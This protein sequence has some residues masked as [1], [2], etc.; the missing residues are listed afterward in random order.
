MDLDCDP[1]QPPPAK[2]TTEPNCTTIDSLGDD[3]LREILLLLPSLT[4]LIRAAFTCRA[5]R[6]AVASSPSF[7]RRFRALHPSPPLGLFFTRPRSVHRPNVPALPDFVPTRRPDK[8]L[9]AAVRCGDF[10]I[11]SIP[12]RRGQ[13]PCW[14]IVDCRDGLL[15]LND[16]DNALLGLFNPYSRWSRGVFD[17]PDGDIFEDYRG[18]YGLRSIH[19]IYSDED[20]MSFRVVCLVYDESRVRALV[21]SPSDTRG[22]HIGPWVEVSPTPQTDSEWLEEGMQ[23]NGLFIFWVCVDLK[24]VITLNTTTMEFSVDEFPQ[25]LTAVDQDVSFD[26]GETMDGAPCIVYAVGLSIGVLLRKADDDGVEKWVQDR[27]VPLETQLARII[28][29]LPLPGDLQ[30]NVAAIRN[31]FVYLATSDMY[32][33]PQNPCWFLSLCLETMEL[34]M[35]FQRTF[36]NQI[37]PYVLPWPRSLVGNYGR[38]ALE[39]A[40]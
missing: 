11:T 3:I 19:L 14:N 39:V 24:I 29:D 23:A 30:L 15:L 38:F 36:D 5:W 20:P 4:A 10:F 16:W 9:A 25:C 8:D 34:E 26:V 21:F 22:W 31:G 12:D 28:E 33:E 35:L 7:R 27:V 6:R 17:M 40:P 13:T 32:H 37:Y 18:I 1:T 2:R